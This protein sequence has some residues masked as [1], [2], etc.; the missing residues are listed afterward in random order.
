MNNIDIKMRDNNAIP[1]EQQNLRTRQ[2]V[3]MKVSKVEIE[4]DYNAE[5]AAK[6][7]E[8]QKQM[9]FGEH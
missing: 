5:E 2:R 7:K 4:P 3:P 9:M 8:K 6:L 1:P